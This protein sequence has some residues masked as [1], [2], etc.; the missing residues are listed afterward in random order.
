MAKQK[1]KKAAV[2]KA[3]K[4]TGN[5]P[6]KTVTNYAAV[7]AIVYSANSPKGVVDELQNYLSNNPDAELQKFL[8]DAHTT[9]E[10]VANLVEFLS[11]K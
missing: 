8:D 9:G 11:T 6:V 2:K 10:T 4:N 3:V 7:K 5:A 1:T